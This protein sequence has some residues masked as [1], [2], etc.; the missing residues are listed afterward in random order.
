MGAS[1]YFAGIPQARK[2]SSDNRISGESARA[3]AHVSAT[4]EVTSDLGS[5][6]RLQQRVMSYRGRGENFHSVL[7]SSP[8]FS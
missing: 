1:C 7:Y 2:I 6:R 3:V 8:Y 5:V 4:Q